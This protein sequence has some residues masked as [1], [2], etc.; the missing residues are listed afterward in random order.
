MN[1]HFQA[2]REKYSN[3]NVMQ[4]TAWIPTKFCTPQPIWFVGSPETQ[5]ASATDCHGATIL[6]IKISDITRWY[7]ISSSKMLGSLQAF[8]SETS[9][10]PTVVL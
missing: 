2:K 6:K 1:R 7:F 8:S 3:L 9:V 10:D 4:A 5:E